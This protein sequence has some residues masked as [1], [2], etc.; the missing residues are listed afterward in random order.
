VVT[1]VS[2]LVVQVEQV[3]IRVEVVE[4]GMAAVEVVDK[5]VMV[6]AEVEVRHT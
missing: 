1:V 4:A 2:T 3:E 5:Q 6:E